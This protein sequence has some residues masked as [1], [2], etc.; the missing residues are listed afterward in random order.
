[1]SNKCLPDKLVGHFFGVGSL[2][3]QNPV[4]P[5]EYIKSLR[6]PY[7]YQLT[8]IK[9]EDMIRQIGYLVEGFE[10]KGEFI[11][12][13]DIHTYRSILS[14]DTPLLLDETHARSLYLMTKNGKYEYLKTH[15]TAPASMCFSTRGSDGKQLVSRSM[16]HFYA[17]LTKRI[18][19][20][21]YEHLSPYCDTLILSQD[22]P[23]IGFVCEMIERG[24]V[25]DLSLKHIGNVTDSLYPDD[26]IPAYH[27]CYDWKNLQEEDWHYLWD[28]IPKLI[29]IDV[30]SFPPN[31]VEEQAEK[32]N[33]F[34]EIGGGLAIG[35]LPNVD[36]G[37]SASVIETLTHN[38]KA[39]LEMFKESGVD[40]D[41]LRMNTMLST[42]CGLHSASIKLIHEIH[43]TSRKFPKINEAVY[44][45]MV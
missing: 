32:I 42:H 21:Q 7:T 45:S 24:K 5:L 15:Q 27:Y 20:G 37:Y 13:V 19:R 14:E 23:A 31:M 40:L 4:K 26:V 2:S 41:L 29:H 34:L 35:I 12:D 9:E 33:H 30:L 17:S 18:A 10:E 28:S 6:V 25:E 36:D 1:V 22:D 39:A 38:L 43:E 11:L 3:E 16:F 8:S 44:N